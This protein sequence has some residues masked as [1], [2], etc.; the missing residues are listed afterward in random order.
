MHGQRSLIVR[1]RPS[2]DRVILHLPSYVEAVNHLDGQRVALEVCDRHARPARVEG[3][4]AVVADETVA[5]DDAAELEHW[6][7]GIS[8]RYVVIRIP[9]ARR[10]MDGYS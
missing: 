3:T 10:G 1:Y 5:G 7:P 8:A 6:P 2:A 4:A 9:A